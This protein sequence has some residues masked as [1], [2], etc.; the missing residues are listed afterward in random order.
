MFRPGVQGEATLVVSLLFTGG[1]ILVAFLLFIGGARGGAILVAFLLVHGG[2]H[3]VDIHVG[4]DTM[5]TGILL[6][7]ILGVLVGVEFQGLFQG[8]LLLH[9]L[10]LH[11]EDL[12]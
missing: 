9:P 11:P 7:A 3:I 8:L 2:V 1:A 10:Q 6:E 4:V 5:R 12:S